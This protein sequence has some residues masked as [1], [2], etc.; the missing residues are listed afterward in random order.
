MEGGAV[1]LYKDF[2]PTSLHFTP[3]SIANVSL[4][5]ITATYGVVLAGVLVLGMIFGFIVATFIYDP[6][7]FAM[8]WR[9]SAQTNSRKDPVIESKYEVESGDNS[10]SLAKKVR[11]ILLQFSYFY[12]P[13]ICTT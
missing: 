9:V 10:E 6:T 11:A 12:S 2:F 13:M 3:N 8:F 4:F 1:N 7:L 5:S